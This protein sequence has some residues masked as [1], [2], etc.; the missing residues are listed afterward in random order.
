MALGCSAGILPA[1]PGSAGAAKAGKMPALRSFMPAPYQGIV[2]RNRGR[3]PHWEAEGGTYFVTFRLADSFP[4][5]VLQ[6]FEFERHDILRTARQQ[7]RDFTA[8]ELKRLDQLFSERIDKYLD[9]GA[10][11]C[12]LARPEIADLVSEALRH[13]DATRYRLHAWC[14]MPNHVHAVF[15]AMPGQSLDR[16]LHSWKSFTANR[17]NAILGATGE[18]WQREYYDRLIRNAAEFAR[19]VRYVADNPVRADLANW[20]WVWV[21]AEAPAL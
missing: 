16:I 3:L 7:G 19:F 15:G 14:I 11:A 18:F 4:Q 1:G 12:H 9:S 21:R 13:F 17:A 8:M 20:R 5:S 2:V 6:S 10:G